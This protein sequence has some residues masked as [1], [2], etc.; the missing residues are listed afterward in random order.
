MSNFL[1]SMMSG[2]TLV[3]TPTLSLPEGPV[4]PDADN[5]R[6]NL[7]PLPGEPQLAPLKLPGFSPPGLLEDPVFPK[8]DL[9]TLLELP[10]PEPDEEPP[11]YQLPEL[12]ETWSFQEPKY[13]EPK[14]SQ[15]LPDAPEAPTFSQPEYGADWSG[16]YPFKVVQSLEV[17][18]N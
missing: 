15:P 1:K 9:L 5:F 17:C 8:V 14:R 4:L 3:E 11:E 6:P 18:L 12:M 16:K 2:R 10:K 13:R 7:Q